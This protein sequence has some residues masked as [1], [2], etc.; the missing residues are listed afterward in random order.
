MRP[1]SGRDTLAEGAHMSLARLATLI[2]LLASA[3]IVA[4]TVS[5][6]SAPFAFP[7]ATRTL[8]PSSPAVL[9]GGL[10]VLV[11]DDDV[12]VAWHLPDGAEQAAFEVLRPD[13]RV[14]KRLALDGAAGSVALGRSQLPPGVYLTRFTAGRSHIE[15][16]MV[17]R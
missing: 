4:E 5:A 14:V 3:A 13:G 8:A 1:Q 15:D 16:K 17:V 10:T 2:A 6:S 11:R 12:R 7:T 9:R